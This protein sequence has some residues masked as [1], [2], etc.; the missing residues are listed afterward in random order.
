MLIL[1]TVIVMSLSNNNVIEKANTAV[2]ASN[3]KNMEEAANVA[4]GEVLLEQGDTMTDSEYKDAIINRMKASGVSD[5]ELAKY[6]IT[7][8]DGKA[9]VSKAGS[10]SATTLQSIAVGDVWTNVSLNLPLEK[11]ILDSDTEIAIQEDNGFIWIFEY[12]L[13]DGHPVIYIYKENESDGVCY[14]KYSWETFTYDNKGDMET[15]EMGW[16][17]MEDGL[18]PADILINGIVLDD[19]DFNTTLAS[20]LSSWFNV[21]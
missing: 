5:T 9:S 17:D 8:T 19:E 16:S 20:Q 21:N 10:S 1:A 4:L 13:T 12:Y 14:G 6:N 3:L 11:I 15:V 7:Y 18:D 2:S